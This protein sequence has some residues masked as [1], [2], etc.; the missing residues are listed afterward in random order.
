VLTGSVRYPVTRGVSFV[1]GT[2][3][4]YTDPTGHWGISLSGILNSAIS[5][6]GGNSE[7]VVNTLDTISTYADAIGAGIDT[8]IAAGDV[9]SAAV[10]ALTGVSAS[11]PT[12]GTTSQT[13]VPA[14]ALVAMGAFELNPLTRGALL[15]GNILA[16][17]STILTGI[18]DAITG[19]T[20]I[21][22][23]LDENGYSYSSSIGRD[24]VTSVSTCLL[25][26][27]SPIGLSSAPIAY[28]P[29]ANDLGLLDDEPFSILPESIPIFNLNI[30][31]QYDEQ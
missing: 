21:T 31:Q 30:G 24:T 8:L 11:I 22:Y 13:T 29:L 2:P 18:S 12:G 14:G 16:T 7:S 4:K 10:G 27:V 17:A 28:V 19:D 26:W 9:A 15:A 1:R 23:S 5:F 20:D 6:F 25:G 3:V